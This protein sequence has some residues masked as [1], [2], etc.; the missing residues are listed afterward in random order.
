[1]DHRSV[2][3]Y[4]QKECGLPLLSPIRVFRNVVAQRAGDSI[5]KKN[6]SR[7]KP[8]RFPSLFRVRQVEEPCSSDKEKQFDI[9]LPRISPKDLRIGE[10]LG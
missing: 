2:S 6:A 5:P 4:R 3:T 7:I 9:E 8:V 10:C 1:M